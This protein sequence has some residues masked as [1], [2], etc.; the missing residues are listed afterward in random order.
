MA[1]TNYKV[2]ITEHNYEFTTYIAWVHGSSKNQ[3]IVKAAALVGQEKL[4][5]EYQRLGPVAIWPEGLMDPE[6]KLEVEED[7]ETFWDMRDKVS[8]SSD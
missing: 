8:V 5:R 3:A 2:T 1:Q 6:I 7:F 4:R